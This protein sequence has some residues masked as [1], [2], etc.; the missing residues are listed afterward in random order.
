MTAL[1]QNTIKRELCVWVKE[2]DLCLQDSK[3]LRV[4]KYCN[5]WPESPRCMG[6]S[7]ALSWERNEGKNKTEL[8][9]DCFTS[10]FSLSD[11]LFSFFFCLLMW[12]LIQREKDHSKVTS[13]LVSVWTREV[14]SVW[15]V[16]ALWLSFY[17]NR[18][19]CTKFILYDVSSS[20]ILCPFLSYPSLTFSNTHGPCT[21]PLQK[22][23]SRAPAKPGLGS[24]P[25]N[26]L[27]AEPFVVEN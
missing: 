17:I 15:A 14:Q 19:I 22:F 12:K 16:C 3:Q 23:A 7:F 27:R 21:A 13:V 1:E 24:V 6:K 5:S 20:N 18:G 8:W 9:K 10:Y 25:Q 26:I 2:A 4:A 11:F